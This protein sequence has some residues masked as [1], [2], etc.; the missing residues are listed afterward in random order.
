MG[1]N[2]IMIPINIYELDDLSPSRKLFSSF[3]CSVDNMHN[4]I[5]P[6]VWTSH[7]FD[8]FQPAIEAQNPLAYHIIESLDRENNPN[9][10]SSSRTAQQ[11][12]TIS[13]S[14]SLS[15]SRPVFPWAHILDGCCT[16]TIIFMPHFLP[17]RLRS[18]VN[19]HAS[20]ESMLSYFRKLI[21]ADSGLL[22]TARLAR[23]YYF[24]AVK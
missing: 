14:L 4:R 10:W 23:F 3:I 9:R 2:S 11:F 13:L 18:L 20:T 16:G 17:T 19:R 7:G 21:R 24:I 12:L 22:F 8:D 15:F 5:L 1:H 6:Q